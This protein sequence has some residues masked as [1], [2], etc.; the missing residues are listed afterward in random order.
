MK[1]FGGDELHNSIFYRTGNMTD[2]NCGKVAILNVA[3]V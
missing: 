2:E 3:T 1:K